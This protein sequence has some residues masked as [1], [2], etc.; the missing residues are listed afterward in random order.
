[1][2][3]LDEFPVALDAYLHTSAIHGTF[4]LTKDIVA[5]GRFVHVFAGLNS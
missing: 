5:N 3:H 2:A 1:M 4:K